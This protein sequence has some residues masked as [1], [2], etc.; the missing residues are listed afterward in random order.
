[1]GGWIWQSGQVLLSSHSHPVNNTSSL[2]TLPGAKRSPDIIPDLPGLVRQVPPPTPC[3]GWETNAGV[4]W[5]GVWGCDSHACH[6]SPHGLVL[7][8]PGHLH[9]RETAHGPPS[10][11]RE[12]RDHLVEGRDPNHGVRAVSVG[13]SAFWLVCG[14]GRGHSLLL[15][16]LQGLLSGRC[17]TAVR[18]MGGKS[19]S[20]KSLAPD[21][22]EHPWST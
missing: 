13:S 11:A 8:F 21:E 1:M 20:E 18:S 9:P 4:R 19:E 15:V 10:P 2:E 3:C 6:P 22:Q 16:S 5:T 7:V 14:P 12:L 17:R